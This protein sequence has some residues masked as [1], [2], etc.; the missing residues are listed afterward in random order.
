MWPQAFLLLLAV[1]AAGAATL[2]ALIAAAQ[3]RRRIYRGAAGA[4]GVIAT[5]YVLLVA[6]VAAAAPNR[7]LAL[8][9]EKYIC[10]LDCHLAYSVL[11]VRRQ[12]DSLVVRLNIR[13]DAATIATGRPGNL[14]VRPGPRSVRLMD[15]QGKRYPPISLGDLSRELLP[16]ASYQT[17]LIFDVDSGATGLVLYLADAD[18]T[19]MVLVGSENALLRRPVGFRL[20][21]GAT[22]K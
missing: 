18:P 22:S 4:A 13:F 8:G 1:G 11:D 3:G 19:K 16:G 2:L 12:R 17:D 10:E 6:G 20:E 14:P 5:G 7:A 9:E 21:G 15:S